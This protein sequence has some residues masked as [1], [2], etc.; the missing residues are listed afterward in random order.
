MFRIKSDL[1]AYCQQVLLLVDIFYFK[2]LE[3]KEKDHA[4]KVNKNLKKMYKNFLSEQNQKFE[5]F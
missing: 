1:S 4:R 3:L 5:D 2:A